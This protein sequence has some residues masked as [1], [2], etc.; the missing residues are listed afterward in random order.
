MTAGRDIQVVLVILTLLLGAMFTLSVNRMLGGTIQ[1]APRRAVV[2]SADL[3]KK[4]KE[5]VK[6]APAPAPSHAKHKKAAHKH[7]RAAARKSHT[8]T[9]AAAA[10]TPASQVSAPSSSTTT[11][12][13]T[14]KPST[15]K[16]APKRSTPAPKKKSSGGGGGGSF[17]NTG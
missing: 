9:P 7:R 1:T 3:D 15:P 4:Y 17:Y 12:S 5:T 8:S 2:P 16:P 13:V 10:T 14:P 11:P 6:S